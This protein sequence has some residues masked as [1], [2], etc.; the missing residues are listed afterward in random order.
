VQV[1]ANNVIRGNFDQTTLN[2][3]MSA[4]LAG[5]FDGLK[6]RYEIIRFGGYNHTHY[7]RADRYWL[8][9]NENKRF[10]VRNYD[11]YDIFFRETIIICLAVCRNLW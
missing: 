10:L 5:Y 2:V 3:F 9:V 8:D 7:T 6:R 11:S 1:V 4:I